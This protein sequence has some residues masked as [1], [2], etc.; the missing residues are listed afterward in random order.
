MG[1]SSKQIKN[2][3]KSYEQLPHRL[4][5]IFKKN[6]IEIINDSK[7]TNF[8]S[9]VASINSIENSIILISGGRIK[10]GD[11][12]LWVKIIIEKIDDVFLYG[13]GSE[14]LKHYLQEGGFRKNIFIFN[15]LKDLVKE[16]VKYAKKHNKEVILFSPSCSSFD[17]FKNYEERG[18]LFK[19]LISK[20]YLN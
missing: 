11:Y 8:D 15:L 13:E 17:Q 3:L 2:G 14:L 18:N 19:K 5:T 10:D 1:L 9:T 4:E 12:K 16:V 6:N 20:S 7:A